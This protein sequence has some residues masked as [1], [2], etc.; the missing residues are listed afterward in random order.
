MWTLV[1]PGEEPTHPVSSN[2]RLWTTGREK[3]GGRTR[4][5][6]SQGESPRPLRTPLPRYE[7]AFLESGAVSEPNLCASINA[8]Q[9]LRWVCPAVPSATGRGRES[10][11]NRDADT[12]PAA[13]WRPCLEASR[14]G[15]PLRARPRP[16]PRCRVLPW[17]RRAEALA[18]TRGASGLS[19][20]Q[21][22]SH[23]CPAHPCHTGLH[24]LLPSSR[25]AFFLLGT[26]SLL[27]SPP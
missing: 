25:S 9:E 4:G 12:D 18:G 19:R 5:L 15:P 7:K 27:G 6:S 23:P 2:P 1:V 17:P 8:C 26:L 14:R 16:C 13:P 3:P 10:P 22:S 21:G 20:G 24:A 11:G